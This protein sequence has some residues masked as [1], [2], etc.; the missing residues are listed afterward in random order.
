METAIV[1]GVEC[2][3]AYRE[4]KIG[5]TVYDKNSK[6]TYIATI[7]DADDLNWIVVKWIDAVKS[8]PTYEAKQISAI[9][10][11]FENVQVRVGDDWYYMS[12]ADLTKLLQKS[13]AKFKIEHKRK[14]TWATPTK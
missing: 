5:S 14:R 12:Y 8:P 3:I 1:N 4:T 10:S 6:T 9:S 13:R 11:A 7:E 2:V